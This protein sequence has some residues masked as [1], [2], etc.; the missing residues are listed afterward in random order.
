MPQVTP[1]RAARELKRTKS[2]T[3]K[4]LDRA[5]I[6]APRDPAYAGGEGRV[7]L[8]LPTMSALCF[9]ITNVQSTL[10]SCCQM[11]KTSALVSC[12]RSTAAGPASA[13]T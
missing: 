9:L 8:E 11:I 12:A 10:H 5:S 4:A 13:P 2:D 6:A 3:T 7:D 1:G